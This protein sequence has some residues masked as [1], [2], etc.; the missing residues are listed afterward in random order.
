MIS[1]H[2]SISLNIQGNV[3]VIS[4][5][6][7]VFSPLSIRNLSIVLRQRSFQALESKSGFQ[8]ASEFCQL[9]PRDNG[10]WDQVEFYGFLV[11][12]SLDLLE[13]EPLKE[14]VSMKSMW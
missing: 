7:L 8:V 2:T 6:I 3:T 1:R 12:E 13:E 11:V 10:Q 9:Q 5:R 4:L 14:V